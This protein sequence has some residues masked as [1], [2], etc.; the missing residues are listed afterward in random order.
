MGHFISSRLSRPAGG[1]SGCA[2]ARISLLLAVCIVFLGL[3]ASPGWAQLVP[4][5]ADV[6]GVAAGEVLW[7]D[8]DGDGDQDLLVVG[9]GSGTTES[10]DPTARLYENQGDGTFTET[11]TDL[12][13]VSAG[14]AAFADFD[15]DGDLDLI[16][17]GNQGGFSGDNLP[18]NSATL[19]ENDGTGSFTPVNAGI[20]GVTVGSVDWGD[21]DGDGDLDLV[22]TGNVGGFGELNP[23]CPPIC[24]DP[25]PSIRIYEN[26]GDGTFSQ[27]DAGISEGVALG[28]SSFGDYDGDGDLDL[29]VSGGQGSIEDPVPFSALYVNDGTGSFTRANAGLTDLAGGATTWADVDGDG[30][31]DLLL[32]GQDAQEVP[33]TELYLT[34]GESLSPEPNDLVDVAGGQIA[35]SDV[36][37]DGDVDLLVTGRDTSETPQT[38]LYRND[39]TGSFS[40][41]EADLAA[42]EGSAADWGHLGPEAD[43]DL[44]VVGRD[45]DSVATAAVYENQTDEPTCPASWTLR[46][47]ITDADGRSGVLTLGQGPTATAGL[48]PS[49]NEVERSPT[50]P[51]APFDLRFGDTDLPG[52]DLGKGTLLDL[53]PDDE[54]TGEPLAL[55]NAPAVWRLEV[56]SEDAPWTVAW[57][58]EVFSDS[59]GGTPA[60]LVDADTGGDELKVDMTATDTATVSGD[61]GPLEIRLDPPLTREIPLAD[62]WNLS[63]IPVDAS[64]PFGELLPSCTSGFFYAPDQGYQVIE[65]DADVPPGQGV[66]ANCTEGTASV[67]GR[68]P[69]STRTDVQDG[70]NL[71][72]PFTAP[73]ASDAVESSP[74]GIVQT[75]FYEFGAGYS[76]A[77]TL[78]PGQ[79]Y[80]IKV[81]Q[82]G[83]LDLS[84]EADASVPWAA[85]PEPTAGADPGV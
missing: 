43:P 16:I 13:G 50:P 32:A 57:T 70:W 6:A 29:V 34:D 47:T 75:P 44:A 61:V 15:D 27:M 60:W 54:A 65:S 23:L 84:G 40:T 51:A 30:D 4:T 78:Q 33:Q 14:A 72:G 20:E 53:R 66:F 19:Y 49:C 11:E 31:L 36:D 9:N 56:E 2:G 18:Q 25:E 63:S 7:G 59:L 26:E 48:D 35:A 17:T 82:N 64:A 79:G 71:V 28:A 41:V 1:Q 39:G 77:D 45:A 3:G 80:W 46:V 55:E 74:P 85:A 62:G 22:V 42:V 81:A 8:V 21:V 76:T 37:E 83:T 73:V 68:T 5:D 12:T 58:P 52:V 69:D 10:A 24:N 67:E 38:I